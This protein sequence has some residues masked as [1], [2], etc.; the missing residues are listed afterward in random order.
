MYDSVLIYS[1]HHAAQQAASLPLL[2]FL[3]TSVIGD[4]TAEFK[5]GVEN[6]K[7]A[8]KSFSIAS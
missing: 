3:M 6:I 4:R 5:R 7:L 8:L 1:R 2:L